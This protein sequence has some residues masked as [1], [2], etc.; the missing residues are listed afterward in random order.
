VQLP[1]NKK[2]ITL[3]LLSILTILVFFCSYATASVKNYP[4]DR[5]QFS[6]P[7]A[8]GMTST[9]LLEMMEEI[10]DKGYD[11]QSI[12]IVRNGYLVLDAY[13]NPF[14]DGQKHEMYSVTKSVMS[15][16]IGI[17]I[18]KGYIKDV[19]QT[20]TQLFPNKKIDN[21]DNLKKSLTLKDLLVMTSG[22]DCNDGSANKWAG[23][24]SMRKSN[25]WSQY[26]LNLPMAHTPG[27]Y[28]HYC[29][30]VSHLLSA[31]IYESTEM[32]TLDFAR[33]HLFDPL[34]IKNI[35]WEESPEGTNNGY[36]G[37]RLQPRD[38]AK[39]GL[40]YLNKGNW[41][42]K[43]I[44]SAEWVREST[45]PYI[46]GRW[47]DEDYGYQWWINPAGYYSAVGMFGQAIY[48]VPD[49]NLVATFTSNIKDRNMYISG[50]LLREYILPA[51]VSSGPLPPNPPEMERLNDFLKS[52]TKEPTQ[53]IIW[54]TE[55]EG[56]AKDG[57]FKRAASPSF[58]FEYPLDCLKAAIRQSDQIMRMETPSGSIIT[59]AIYS[60][61][62]DWRRFFFSMKL[63]DFGP[64]AYASWMK[65]YGSNITVIS[66]KEITL[67]C[68][69]KAYRTD[70]KWQLK[71]STPLTTN[72]VSTYK[73][74]KSIYI[75]VHQF[76]D[77]GII[78]TII[79]SLRFE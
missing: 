77:T 7:E 40:L 10:K 9:S 11:I 45:H 14:E 70:I 67:N 64:K 41:E 52:I 50:T 1:Q 68:G 61:P 12:S 73:K 47:N 56:T 15:A 60:I 66:N 8:Q 55:K 74:D 32:R 42:N 22:L 6:T 43:Q 26:I 49:K 38:M 5:W 72:L 44:I 2:K 63:E 71:N 62:K 25:D 27:A 3:Y 36:M 30:G 16:L 35:E 51:I 54:L 39:I 78:K 24:L 33:K 18:D 21:L 58:Q 29:N 31:I 34:G 65:D 28:F 17:A 53:G 13:I 75:A 57:M 76:K 48:V 19:H 59:A 69:T 37:L 46:D 23:T 4:T 20:L 79:E